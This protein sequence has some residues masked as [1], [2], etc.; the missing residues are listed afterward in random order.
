M[1]IYHFTHN[2]ERLLFQFYGKL[3]ALES[4]KIQREITTMLA[5]DPVSSITFDMKYVEYISSAFLSIC[6]DL[7]RRVG[8]DQFFVINDA[9]HVRKIF[10]I[11]GLQF[12]VGSV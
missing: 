5:H 11:V 2:Y 6:V 12:S 8:P 7:Y 4:D 1:Y 10:K 9:P 3:N